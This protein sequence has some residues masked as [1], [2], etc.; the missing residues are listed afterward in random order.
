MSTEELTRRLKE[1]LIC[2]ICLDCFHDPVSIHC[3]HTFCQ[4]CITGYWVFINKKC[5]HCPKCRKTSRKKI[6]KRNRELGNI[7]KIVPKL[8]E[9]TKEKEKAKEKVCQMHQE[10]LKLFCKNDQM[11]IC[12][13]CDKSKE[14]KDHTVVPV[15]QEFQDQLSFLKT[16]REKLVK[17]QSVNTARNKGALNTIDA[18]IQKISLAF[19]QINQSLK[20][21]KQQLLAQWNS[22]KAALKEQEIH[23]ATISE[24]ISCLD[25]FITM[26]EERWSILDLE[27]LQEMQNASMRLKQKKVLGFDELLPEMENRLAYQNEVVTSTLR[28]LEDAL[29]SAKREKSNSPIAKKRKS[30]SH[31]RESRMHSSSSHQ[32]DKRAPVGD[33]GLTSVKKKEDSNSPIEKKRRLEDQAFDYS[34]ESRKPIQCPLC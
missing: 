31:S 25:S 30:E 6:L 17:I 13:I 19:K 26:A 29:I 2:S 14:H 10:P 11:A 34:P 27:F 4:A 9:K 1:E 5:F 20:E 24:E 18:G 32:P 16:N 23:N 21:Q 28:K 8:D 12:V 22:L 33:N 15:E 7:A 3:G